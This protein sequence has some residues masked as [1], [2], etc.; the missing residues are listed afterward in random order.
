MSIHPRQPALALAMSLLLPGY[1][2]LYNGEINK[3][4][5]L[6]LSF[7]LLSVPGIAFVALVLPAAAMLPVLLASIAAT[8]AIWIYGMIDAWRGARRRREY[9]RAP[10]QASGLYALV[11]ILCNVIVL[12]LTVGYVRS[13]EVES[14]RIPSASMSP[15]ILPGDILFADKSYNCPGC[16]RAVRRGDIAIFTYPNDRT[17]NYIKRV[18]ALP[19]DRVRIHGI[20]VTVNSQPLTRQTAPTADGIEVTESEG[21]RQWRVL[22]AK[23]GA[24]EAD[25]TV[26]PGQ[27]FVLGDN[28]GASKDS[29]H[30]GTVPLE[31]VVG[32][33]RQIWFSHGLEGVRW[34]RLGLVVQ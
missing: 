5:W 9:L 10:W 27:V 20:E 17:M 29:R 7:A 28:R 26:P 23:D 12:P 4:I 2:Q 21:E 6:F 25:L 11:F 19:G 8:L 22:W 13:H 32:L 14:F 33:A 15:G 31:D 24:A 30:F 3:A 18:I 1:G 34:S 16:R